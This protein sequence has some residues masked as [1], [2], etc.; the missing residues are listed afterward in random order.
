MLL[1]DL[2]EIVSRVR[3]HK[4]RV[5]KDND[6]HVYLNKVLPR[7]V[8]DNIRSI[9]AE[10][11]GNS[12]TITGYSSYEDVEER[13]QV[14]D[15]INECVRSGMNIVRET[16]HHHHQYLILELSK[17]N[18]VVEVTYQTYEFDRNMNPVN[19]RYSITRLLKKYGTKA[20][21]SLG[22]LFKVY[23]PTAYKK[24][25]YNA[26]LFTTN[27]NLDLSIDHTQTID[28]IYYGLNTHDCL[29]QCTPTSYEIQ[30]ASGMKIEKFK[31]IRDSARRIL[32]DNTL[33][34]LKK[35]GCVLTIKINTHRDI[36]RIKLM[37]MPHLK[38]NSCYYTK[39][40]IG[41]YAIDEQ[42]MLLEE[43][44]NEVAE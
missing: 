2:N 38:G 24:A 14:A 34:K 1:K 11:Y 29:R 25:V 18:E 21:H 7:M 42:S 22:Y 16:K 4:R 27:I 17:V 43:S 36:K 3:G 26:F 13:K 19:H 39:M 20:T 23:D 40:I 12:L 6:E 31:E 32:K 35:G 37:L 28:R 9:E 30:F 5:M 15:S 41:M 8:Y 33:V 44:R 10:V